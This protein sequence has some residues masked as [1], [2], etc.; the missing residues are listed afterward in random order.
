[1]VGLNIPISNLW[2]LRF[3]GRLGHTSGPFVVDRGKNWGEVTIG[4][5]YSFEEAKSLVKAIG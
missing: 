1:M 3:E 4:V 5:T 2:E